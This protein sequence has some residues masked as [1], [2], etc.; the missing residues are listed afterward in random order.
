MKSQ[1]SEWQITKFVWLNYS[2]ND[3]PSTMTIGINGIN[4]SVG[5]CFIA[6]GGEG[7]RIEAGTNR[8]PF[9][10]QLPPNVPSS[11]EGEIGYVR[12]T[13]EATME[14]PWKFN[15]VTRSAF[16]V[17]SLVDLNLEP[18]EFKVISVFSFLCCKIFGCSSKQDQD[19][20]S[21]CHDQDSKPQDQDSENTA[22]R[23]L[24]TRQC[25]EASPHCRHSTGW[26]CE[27]PVLFLCS[28]KFSISRVSVI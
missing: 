9:M 8:Y 17:I 18:P 20:D 15:H 14:R 12:Y 1:S 5:M 4:H 28:C 3:W 19:R 13:A 11:F 6:A 24:Q 2:L 21:D 10:F 7:T 27:V 26:L 22:S 16:T 23:R 25:L